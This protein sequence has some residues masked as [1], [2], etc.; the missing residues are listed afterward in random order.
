MTFAKGWDSWKDSTSLR[1]CVAT[2]NLRPRTI[3]E[4][5]NSAIFLENGSW[6]GGRERDHDLSAKAFGAASRVSLLRRFV[7]S[8]DDCA[9]GWIAFSEHDTAV[10]AQRPARLDY[11]LHLGLRLRHAAR[12]AGLGNRRRT[13]RRPKNL[14]AEHCN[15]LASVQWLPAT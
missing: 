14:Q 11:A 13:E 1:L 7:L 12:Y 4:L 8:D 15:R 2:M 5:I 3:A 9:G 10:A 6:K